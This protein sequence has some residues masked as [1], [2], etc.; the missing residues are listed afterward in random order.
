[1]S[2][3]KLL[4]EVW[5]LVALE[6]PVLGWIGVYPANLYMCQVRPEQVSGG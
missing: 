5:L 3:S 1:M 4:L 2:L 6:V